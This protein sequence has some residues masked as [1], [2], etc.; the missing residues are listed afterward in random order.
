MKRLNWLWALLLVLPLVV[1]LGC[2]PKP[3]APAE[4]VEYIIP[5]SGDYTG[6][7]APLIKWG[8]AGDKAMF[9]WWNENFGKKIGVKLTPEVFDS[10]YDTATVAAMWPGLLAKRPIAYFGLGGPDVAALKERVP[11]DKVPIVMTTGT[12]G[13]DWKPVNWIIQP[14]PTYSH[15]AI[16]FIEWVLKDWKENRPLRI[17]SVASD[18]TPAYV[19]IVKGL[20]TAVKQ[21]YVGKVEYLGCAWVPV[22]P[23]DI[24]DSLRPFIE[25]GVDYFHIQTNTSHVGATY[26]ACVTLQKPTKIFTSTHNEL[27][28]YAMLKVLTWDKMEGWA[29]VGAVAS[30]LNKNITA[31]TEVWSNYHPADMEAEKDWNMVTL[32]FSVPPLLLG[33]AVEAAVKKVGAAN[34]TG[35]V[36]YNALKEVNLD[37]QGCMGLV[38]HF[39]LRADAPFSED[40]GVQVSVVKD[41]VYTNATPTWVPIPEIPKW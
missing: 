19:D 23:V 8:V 18:V 14:R 10:R 39:K 6:P 21:K 41:G 17:A 22:V 27:N 26:K 33:R 34:L 16:G 20:E 7:Y 32:Q 24:T 1:A 35:E 38:K 12:Y 25:K 2:A 13:Y 9:D 31:Y 29:S 15:E 40:L 5:L 37:E 28:L 36:V 3:A 30:P 4:I 11:D